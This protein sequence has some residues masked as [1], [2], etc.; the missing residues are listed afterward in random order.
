[1]ITATIEQKKQHGTQKRQRCILPLRTRTD[2]I[3]SGWEIT[4]DFK[5]NGTYIHGV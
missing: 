1:M 4:E 5:D 2:S 3:S